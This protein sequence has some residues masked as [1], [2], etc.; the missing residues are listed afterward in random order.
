M[1][2]QIK[3]YDM[4]KHRIYLL[5]IFMMISTALCAQGSKRIVSLAASI[6]RNLYELGAGDQIVGCT[7]FCI[8]DPQDSIAVVAEAVNVNLERIALLKPDI[9]LAG[10]L[11][12]PRVIESLK[13]MGIQT[14]QWGQPKD[15]NEICTQFSEMGEVVEKKEA[16]QA[17]IQ[18][19]QSEVTTLS[20]Q[21]K[22]KRQ[23]RVFMELS[24]SPLFTALP[25]TF[26]GDYI[27]KAGGKNIAASLHDGM[28]SKEYVLMQ[29]P[30][31]ILLVAMGMTAESE[32]QAWLKL[33]MTDA[34]KN[35]R[36]HILSD[37]ISSPTPLSFAATVK[38]LVGILEKEGLYNN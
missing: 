18:K 11:T 38:E 28:V 27:T 37:E 22:D 2:N 16:A 23:P 12:H 13:K 32:K 30:E 35:K 7:K 14:R 33:N 31:V 19:A 21:L 3:V 26:M 4:K 25:N 29:N 5:G 6:T 36:I 17:V 1:P 10:G 20:S 15:F 34:V 24:G 9:V 8:T